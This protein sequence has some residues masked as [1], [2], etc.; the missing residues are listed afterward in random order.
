MPVEYKIIFALKLS[1]YPGSLLDLI[2]GT[3]GNVRDKE[4][5]FLKIIELGK[6]C[7]KREY[8]YR[9]TMAKVLEFFEERFGNECVIVIPDIDYGEL[10]DDTNNRSD[11]NVLRKGGFGTDFKRKWFSMAVAMER[12]QNLG[13]NTP[14]SNEIQMRRNFNEL[15]HSNHFLHNNILPLY[16]DSAN[17]LF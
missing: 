10:R 16:G 3:A 11:E 8:Q 6:N 15:N 7:T 13:T 1:F 9:P 5:F 14:E 17:G 12:I 4:N 2:D